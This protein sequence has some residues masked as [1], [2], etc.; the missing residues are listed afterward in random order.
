MHG[1][2][3]FGLPGLLA[4]LGM[5]GTCDGVDLYGPEPLEAF[6]LSALQHSATRIGYSLRFHPVEAAASSGQPLLVDGEFSVSCTPLKHRVPAFGYRI[7]Q[8]ERPGR[9][10]IAQAKAMRLPPAG[11]CASQSRRNRHLCRWT[12]HRWPRALRA[13]PAGCSV[14]YCTDTVFCERAVALAQGLI[15]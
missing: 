14:V 2:H 10:D 4:S 6:V 13:Q 11:I 5:A 15:C 8:S 9:F 12:A 3:V 7:Q 1:D